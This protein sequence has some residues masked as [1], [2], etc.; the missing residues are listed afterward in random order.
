MPTYAMVTRV[1]PELIRNPRMLEELER[2]AVDAVK[3]YCPE[4]KW[5][6]SYAILGPYD[7]LD[8]FEA[9]DNEMAAKVSTLIRAHGRAHTEV[10]VATDWQKFKQGLHDIAPEPGA[11]R[12]V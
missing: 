5:L 7:Y 10:W 3:H 4:V 1:V 8:L 12:R 11:E 9:P 2:K 6:Q